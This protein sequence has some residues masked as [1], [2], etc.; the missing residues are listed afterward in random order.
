MSFET[1]DI[2]LYRNEFVW[3]EPVTW[4]SCVERWVTNCRYDHAAIVVQGKMYEALSSGIVS[5][6]IL[7]HI[8]RDNCK[9]IALRPLNKVGADWVVRAKI[10]VGTKYGVSGLFEQL[11][12]RIFGK[13]MGHTQRKRM[14][15]TQ[16]VAW[17][18]GKSE[19]FKFSAKE[20]LED[21]GFEVIYKD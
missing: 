20:F 2:I 14:I 10:K 4:L 6:D 1:G 15:C 16:Y 7:P 18:Y 13:W 17:V 8:L 21:E 3:N 12:Y 19:W 11:I 9:M 5:R